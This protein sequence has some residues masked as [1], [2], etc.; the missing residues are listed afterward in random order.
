MNMVAGLGGVGMC[1]LVNHLFELGKKESVAKE[2]C[3]G[4]AT[5]EV[6]GRTLCLSS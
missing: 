3:R 4:E 1:T 5:I 2:G 6:F